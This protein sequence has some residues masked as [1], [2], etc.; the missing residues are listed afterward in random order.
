MHVAA[1]ELIHARLPGSNDMKK[2]EK[3][4]DGYS[5][6]AGA[7]ARRSKKRKVTFEEPIQWA[8]WGE[9]GAAVSVEV[10]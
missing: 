6:D 1:Y 8:F 7:C 9:P 4:D 10:V 3:K 5:G 2:K